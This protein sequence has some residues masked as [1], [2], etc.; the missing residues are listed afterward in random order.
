MRQDTLTYAAV[1]F[2]LGAGAILAMLKPVLQA[3]A[4]DPARALR[5]E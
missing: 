1:S 5:D 2:L 3:A 4:L